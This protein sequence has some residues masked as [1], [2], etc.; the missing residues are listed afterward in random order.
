MGLQDENVTSTTIQASSVSNI[1]KGFY[2]VGDYD[3]AT[4]SNPESGLI[5]LLRDNKLL[6]S[7]VSGE[8]MSHLGEYV[9]VGSDYLPNQGGNATNKNEYLIIAASSYASETTRYINFYKEVADET[10]S[11]LYLWQP[12]VAEINLQDMHTVSFG[13]GQLMWV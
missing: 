2:A 10:V 7:A 13:T 12:K 4:L 9:W 11:E 1:L 8:G 3:Y 6:S 5:Q